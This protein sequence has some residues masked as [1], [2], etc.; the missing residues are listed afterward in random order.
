VLAR[1]RRTQAALVRKPVRARLAA[2]IGPTLAAVEL[3]DEFQ[4]SA[5]GGVDVSGQL[6]DLPLE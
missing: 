3:A 6:R 4:P 2:P 1:R 5:R